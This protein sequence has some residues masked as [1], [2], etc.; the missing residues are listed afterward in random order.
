MGGKR[1]RRPEFEAVCRDIG[2]TMMKIFALAAR[3]GA[4]SA[5]RATS[6]TGSWAG[7]RAEVMA[8][9]MT[10]RIGTGD[11]SRAERCRCGA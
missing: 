4:P 8:G 1:S 3:G 6:E 2:V 10:C 7:F 11:A 9:L 5:H